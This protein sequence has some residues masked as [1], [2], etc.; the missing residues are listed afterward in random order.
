[1]Y[2]KGFAGY[3]WHRRTAPDSAGT[4][5][6]F[7]TGVRTYNGGLN[8]DGLGRP[9]RSLAEV[10]KAA[11]KRV[12][13]VA[14]VPFSHATPAAGGG[15]HNVDRNNYHAIT[16]EMLRS[17]TLDVIAGPSHPEYGNDG[18]PMKPNYKFISPTDWAG[19][20]LGV[21]AD[22]FGNTWKFID[23][24]D[25][26]VAMAEGDTPDK[27]IMIPRV[28]STLQQER[29]T[30]ARDEENNPAPWST[31][32]GD[33][34]HT[35]NLPTLSQLAAAALNAVDDDPDGFF[36][37][38]EG[39]AV[40]WAMHANQTGRMIEEYMDFDAAV[41]MVSGYLDAGTNGHTW[42]NTLVV[43]TADHDHL[44]VGPDGA[45]V[46]FQPVTDN[47]PGKLPGYRWMSGSHSNRLV[48]V[49]VRGPGMDR[50]AALA[51]K[52]DRFSDGTYEFG[53][54][55]YFHQAELGELLIEL[56]SEDE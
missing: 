22:D 8:V 29:P 3:E 7:M 11:G 26:I 21:M 48:P 5:S 12:G 39:G 36:L 41:A 25:A 16:G 18:R 38:I 2:P 37:V 54:G 24:T 19:V 6:Q 4:M 56:F 43:V 42:D 13:V 53:V 34:P 52:E 33:D 40:D 28:L 51:T 31:A 20:K 55:R 49:F 27:L 10:A 35:A 46:P 15:A 50:V 30:D 17:G 44:L 23:D 45:T 32:P 1:H 9:V 14:S 47:G